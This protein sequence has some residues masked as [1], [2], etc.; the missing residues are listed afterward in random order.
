MQRMRI[1]AVFFDNAPREGDAPR[2]VDSPRVGNSPSVE[3]LPIMLM[4]PDESVGDRY[5]I[6]LFPIR[7]VFDKPGQP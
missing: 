2:V 6:M 1:P 4:L 3:L 5:L 7:V